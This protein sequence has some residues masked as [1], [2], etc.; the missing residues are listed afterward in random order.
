MSG[1]P[2]TQVGRGPT[3]I[4]ESLA[5]R[6]WSKEWVD[7]RNG[8]TIPSVCSLMGINALGDREVGQFMSEKGHR[9]TGT[10]TRRAR[11]TRFG[12]GRL[13]SPGHPTEAAATSIGPGPRRNLSAGT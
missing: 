13:I 3:S 2:T 4:Q 11:Q 10:D 7:S 5:A 8:M 6:A 1:P 12:E 9:P